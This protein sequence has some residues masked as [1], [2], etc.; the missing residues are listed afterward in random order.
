MLNNVLL[1]A[2]NKLENIDKDLRDIKE[3]LRI[4]NKIAYLEI[5]KEGVFTVNEDNLTNNY[6]KNLAEIGNQLG[7]SFDK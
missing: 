2:S 7:I 6:A 3:Q 5:I 1:I 4:A